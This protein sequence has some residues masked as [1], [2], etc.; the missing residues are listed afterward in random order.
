[1]YDRV[2][3]VIVS[4]RIRVIPCMFGDISVHKYYGEHVT[5]EMSICNNFVIIDLFDKLFN[6]LFSVINV[7][8]LE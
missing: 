7:I 2:V 8:L 3:R 1:M 4:Y 5:L 6:K